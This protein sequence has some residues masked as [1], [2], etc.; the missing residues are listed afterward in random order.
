[1]KRSELKLNRKQ[2]ESN[3]KIKE[4][5]WEEFGWDFL[6]GWDNRIPVAIYHELSNIYGFNR[7][8]AITLWDEIY[9]EIQHLKSLDWEKDIFDRLDE[10]RES[11]E[12]KQNQLFDSIVKQM[13]NNTEIRPPIPGRLL[14]IVP[15]FIEPST[16][17]M[18]PHSLKSPGLPIPVPRML[19]YFKDNYGLFKNEVYIIWDRYRE[20]MYKKL[21]RKFPNSFLDDADIDEL[22]PDNINESKVVKYFERLP[23]PQQGN[24]FNRVADHLMNSI[25]EIKPLNETTLKTY[26]EKILKILLDETTIDYDKMR[27][28]IPFL[29]KRLGLRTKDYSIDFKSFLYMVDFRFHPTHS[30]PDIK[31]F[32]DVCKD[33]YGLTYEETKYVWYEYKIN[34]ED[35]ILFTDESSEFITEST[36]KQNKFY[37]MI[38]NRMVKETITHPSVLNF[39]FLEKA[40]TPKNK[41]YNYIYN[42][43]K[44]LLNRPL[45]PNMASTSYKIGEYMKNT[46]GVTHEE[47][48]FLWDLYR[49]II[50]ENLSKPI[51]PLSPSVIQIIQDDLFERT[52]KF[53][54]TN[55]PL[56]TGGGGDDYNQRGRNLRGDK[57]GFSVQ[58]YLP[59]SDFPYNIEITR[60]ELWGQLRDYL[61][62][63][64]GMTIEECKEAWHKYRTTICSNPGWP[65]NESSISFNATHFKYLDLVVNQLMNE[66]YVKRNTRF[67]VPELYTPFKHGVFLEKSPTSD[68]Q[69]FHRPQS[70]HFTLSDSRYFNYLNELYGLTSNEIEYVFWWY[71]KKVQ[72]MMKD[73]PLYGQAIN[74]GKDKK[75][76]YLDTVFEQ[77]M[78]EIVIDWENGLI[79]T[80]FIDPHNVKVINYEG[81][82]KPFEFGLPINHTSFNSISSDL[83]YYQRLMVS[84]LIDIYGL[85]VRESEN[86]WYRIKDAMLELMDSK[87]TYITESTDKQ[88][89]YIQYVV[90]TILNQTVIDKENYE[91]R[92]PW[93]VEYVNILQNMGGID[94]ELHNPA[95]DLIGN[96]MG[97]FWNMMMDIYGLSENEVEKVWKI[98]GPTLAQRM[99]DTWYEGYKE[100]LRTI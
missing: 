72:K 54:N 68:Y 25:E 13:I 35:K 46:Y 23:H 49:R 73:H 27:V 30:Y 80:P 69:F 62:N 24:M 7:E 60:E 82:R 84:Y 75:T 89:K 18:Y 92:L 33:I 100:Y 20:I 34:I 1:M 95:K 45:S 94:E 56:C 29:D 76:K 99:N 42:V 70:F 19:G 66:T 57:P 3:R 28:I 41:M 90:D 85:T 31:I 93:G 83:L 65:I 63:T 53:P 32:F 15:D 39:I 21:R 58:M 9:E 12:R 51:K 77:V 44:F 67:D 78:D 47:V 50:I 59:F 52:A 38:I 43:H 8:E 2:Q 64:Y 87:A 4:H 86:L 17:Y 6:S 71:V 55:K 96:M 97:G 61:I 91:I 48:E 40:G 37:N 11:R 88:E 22:F 16:P 74:E 98:Y 10:G 14:L 26:A 79:Y 5:I 36:E 81:E